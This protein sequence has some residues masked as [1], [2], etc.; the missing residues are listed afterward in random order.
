[1]ANDSAEVHVTAEG[2]VI[3]PILVAPLLMIPFLLLLFILVLFRKPPKKFVPKSITIE[4][5]PL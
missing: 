5:T 3:A 4:R 1:M 2:T